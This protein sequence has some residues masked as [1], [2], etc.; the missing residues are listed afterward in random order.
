VDDAI[1]VGK[2]RFADDIV[3]LVNRKLAG[4]EGGAAAVAVFDDLHQ[5]APLIGGEPVRSSVVEHQQIGF[6]EGTE[7]AREATVTMGERSA[8]SRGTRV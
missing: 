6:D 7:Q 4:D 3:P 1:R 5:I 2:G 8:N